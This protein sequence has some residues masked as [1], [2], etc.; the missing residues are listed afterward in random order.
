MPRKPPQAIEP[1][2]EPTKALTTQ[3]SA[4]VEAYLNNGGNGA[5]AARE[6][7]CKEDQAA[8]YAYRFLRHQG[9][10]RAIYERMATEVALSAP[11]AL[12]TI[13]TLMSG[14]RSEFV[15]L[16]AAQDV[17]DRAGIRAQSSQ[18][19]AGEITVKIDL[20]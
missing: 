16:Q 20:G 19:A 8:Q 5:A 7:G 14:A 4:F 6:I 15:R 2:A 1:T 17:L 13:R 10:Q 9:V 12:G 11:K 3:Q 18:L